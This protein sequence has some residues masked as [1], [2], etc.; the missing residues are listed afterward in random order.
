MESVYEF[1][2]CNNLIQLDCD[3][4]SQQKKSSG[5]IYFTIVLE[6]YF[7]SFGYLSCAIIIH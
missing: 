5:K 3:L 2:P 4:P 1:Q 7:L 6:L